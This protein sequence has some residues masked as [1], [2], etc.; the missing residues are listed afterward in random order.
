MNYIEQDKLLREEFDKLKKK[1]A[2][3]TA[4]FRDLAVNMPY[5]LQYTFRLLL[6]LEYL[7]RF[8]IKFSQVSI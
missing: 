3:G 4:G 7:F 5:V 8:S 1:A 2:Y 6:E